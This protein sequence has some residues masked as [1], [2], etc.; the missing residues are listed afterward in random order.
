MVLRPCSFTC[1][2]YGRPGDAHARAPAHHHPPAVRLPHEDVGR[3]RR[4]PSEGRRRLRVR[5]TSARQWSRPPRRP[6]RRRRRV[7]RSGRRCC[8]RPVKRGL[9]GRVSPDRAGAGLGRGQ[10]PRMDVRSEPRATQRSAPRA[11][12]PSAV[13]ASSGPPRCRCCDRRRVRRTHQAGSA[14]LI[15]RI[16]TLSWTATSA[17]GVLCRREPHY[18]PHVAAVRR[19]PP[20]RSGWQVQP[21][22]AEV[23][24]VRRH[25]YRRSGSTAGRS[26]PDGSPRM[27]VTHR[28]MP[29]G[30]ATNARAA[31]GG[32]L[33][34]DEPTRG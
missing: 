15:R 14:G 6:A 25:G 12:R 19:M 24:P 18:C 34:P 16:W 9:V 21:H 7:V 22:P 3:D 8:S 17:A 11:L 5:G 10:R 26:S 13:P 27:A 29:Y 4:R 2:V 32:G 23:A 30:T 1:P 31:R 20:S 28:R 33:S